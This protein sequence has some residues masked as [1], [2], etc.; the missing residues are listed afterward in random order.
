MFEDTMSHIM[1]DMILQEVHRYFTKKGIVVGERQSWW[2]R[3]HDDFI[4]VSEIRHFD[5]FSEFHQIVFRTNEKKECRNCQYKDKAYVHISIRFPIK[6]E[7]MAHYTEFFIDTI[8]DLVHKNPLCT[9][10]IMKQNPD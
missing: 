5:Q 9:T 8:N 2:N 3:T 1:L 7:D 4:Y 6:E 10:C